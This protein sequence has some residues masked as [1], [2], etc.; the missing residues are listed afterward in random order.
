MSTI[1]QKL[2]ALYMHNYFKV[3]FISKNKIV[4]YNKPQRFKMKIIIAAINIQSI[5]FYGSLFG[6]TSNTTR[7]E[8]VMS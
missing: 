6:R 2:A 1:K 4:N 8:R 7:S 3:Y 5:Y